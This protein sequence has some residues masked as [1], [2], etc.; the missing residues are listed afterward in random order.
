MESNSGGLFKRAKDLLRRPQTASSKPQDPPSTNQE[1][2][3]VETCR[4]AVALWGRSLFLNVDKVA[5]AQS[6]FDGSVLETLYQTKFV[7]APGTFGTLEGVP[8]EIMAHKPRTGPR[9]SSGAGELFSYD[10]KLGETPTEYIVVK[11]NDWTRAIIKYKHADGDYNITVETDK[12]GELRFDR[13]IA[14]N[15]RSGST[16]NY[17]EVRTFSANDQEEKP[18]VLKQFQNFDSQRQDWIK[19]V[20]EYEAVGSGSDMRLRDGQEVKAEVNGPV[21]GKYSAQKGISFSQSDGI[22]KT[23]IAKVDSANQAVTIAGVADG[24]SINF[25][26][27]TSATDYLEKFL[28][29]KPGMFK[30][31]PDVVPAIESPSSILVS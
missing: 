23:P 2:Q 12:D 25:P 3:N 27:T 9:S 10:L 8:P 21:R 15:I 6:H 20:M 18:M 5:A 28:K 29:L 13:L 11:G 14:E 4:E 16:G 19:A 17:T 1:R 24:A 7:E 31:I 30:I 26:I 22:F